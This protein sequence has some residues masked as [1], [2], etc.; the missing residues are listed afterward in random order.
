[1]RG[2]AAVAAISI[3]TSALSLRAQTAP[4]PNPGTPLVEYPHPLITEIFFS[5]PASGGDANADGQRDAAGDE[6]IELTNPHA[7]PIN[8]LGYEIADR[9]TASQFRFRF[10]DLTLAPGE[11]VIVFNGHDCQWRGPVGDD[12]RAPEAAHELFSSAWVF[13]ARAPSQYTSF[14]NTAE[15]VLLTSPGAQPVHAIVWG[16]PDDAPP[17]ETAVIE[18]VGAVRGRSVQRLAPGGPLHE[19]P[20]AIDSPEGLLT[21]DLPCSP[22][23]ALPGWKPPEPA[24][25]APETKP[26]ESYPPAPPPSGPPE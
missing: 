14:A 5:V 18:R 21:F 8:L 16:S 17:P 10:P 7:E 1:M 15:F 6:F 22:G 25:A 12:Q 24:P 20:Q 23:V 3:V 11:T 13:T 9:P 19:H 4:P 2:Q 26:A